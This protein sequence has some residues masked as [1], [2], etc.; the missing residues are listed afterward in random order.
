M[1]MAFW[2]SARA[3]LPVW[4]LLGFF[5]FQGASL[6]SSFGAPG[7]P[8]DLSMSPLDMVTWLQVCERKVKHSL[9]ELESD[10]NVIFP[11]K[12]TWRVTLASSLLKLPALVNELDSG[13]NC[14][15]RKSSAC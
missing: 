8:R 15:H 5:G 12:W 2:P 7:L 6:S 10:S 3:L 11:K 4:F 1:R 13:K 9:P 14:R